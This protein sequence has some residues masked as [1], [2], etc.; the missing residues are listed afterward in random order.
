VTSRR[1]AWGG[2]SPGEDKAQEG[3]GWW[4]DLKTLASG[5]DFQ[6]EQSREV[7]QRHWPH[8]LGVVGLVRRRTR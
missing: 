1:I 5:T 8:L 4:R 6:G 7:G 3:I 2:E